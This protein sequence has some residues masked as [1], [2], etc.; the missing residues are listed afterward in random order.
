MY[1]G[2][3]V[4]GSFLLLPLL[5]TAG[6]GVA[7]I[8][9]PANKVVNGSNASP[10]EYPYQVSV[11]KFC[12]GS[13]ITERWVLTAAHCVTGRYVIHLALITY[14]TCAHRSLQENTNRTQC[15]LTLTLLFFLDRNNKKKKFED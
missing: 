3:V 2:K 7:P 8:S 4:K 12:G 5:P 11:D 13:L 10:G 6:C 1:I 15:F 14:W 9:L